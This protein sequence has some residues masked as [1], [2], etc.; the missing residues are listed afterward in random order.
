MGR[1]VEI[2]Q[3]WRFQS[4]IE[5]IVKTVES[6]VARL[7]DGDA[8]DWT[9]F[10]T[11]GGELDLR[12]RGLPAPYRVPG[13]TTYVLREAQC[14]ARLTRQLFETDPEVRAVVALR[15]EDK[16]DAMDRAWV[17][18]SALRERCAR[19]A[20]EMLAVKT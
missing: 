8:T 4:G 12:P 15:G 17:H 6:Q 16:I 14:V 18:E 7:T 20:R 10:L 19:R 11:D 13:S 2:G 1:R 3:V 9:M 5:G